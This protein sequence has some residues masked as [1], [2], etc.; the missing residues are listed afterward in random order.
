MII[1]KCENGHFFDIEKYEVCPTCGAKIMQG[2]DKPFEK[3]KKKG[4]FSKPASKETEK[5]Q[6]KQPLVRSVQPFG[7]SQSVRSV[8]PLSMSP[9]MSPAEPAQPVQSP[10]PFQLESSRNVSAQGWHDISED[11]TIGEFSE[12]IPVQT[13]VPEE[14]DSRTRGYFEINTGSIPEQNNN[15]ADYQD[16]Y[17]LERTVFL[18]EIR[19]HQAESEGRTIG[20]FSTVSP[21]EGDSSGFSM[22]DTATKANRAVN[23]PVEPMVGWLVAIKGVNRGKAY[24]IYSGRNSIGRLS[25]NRIQISG[26]QAISR[27]KH[28]WIIYDPK[29]R[30]FSIK[31]GESSG[32]TYI[33]DVRVVNENPLKPY[34]KI[35]MGDSLFLFVPLCGEKFSWELYQ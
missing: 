15:Q 4:L 21:M 18:E 11:P 8:Q 2:L 30:E 14:D 31:E 9:S 25:S 27:E 3:V 33:D 34:T 22:N 20:Y 28:A 29:H 23:G 7:S 26:D 16:G 32:L 19:K 10:Q 13:I 5:S 35:E 12:A 1:S 24:S 17:G 6:S